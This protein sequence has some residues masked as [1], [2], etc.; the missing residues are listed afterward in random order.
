ML[1]KKQLKKIEELIRRKF[2]VFTYESLGERALT[3]DELNMLKDAGLLRSTVRSFTGDAFALGKVV[4]AIDRTKAIK[5]GFD[6][7]AKLAAKSPITTVEKYTIDWASEHTGQYIKGISDDMVK[8]VKTTVTRA[9]SSAIRAVQDEVVSAI[10]NRKT[11]SELKTA[12][13]HRIDDKYR[14]WQRVAQTEMNNAIQNGIYSSIRDK[15]GPDQLVYKRPNASACKHC[16]RVYLEDDGFTPIIFKMTD[17]KDSNYGLKA[18]NWE[19]TIGSVHPY[20]QC[21]LSVVPDG[22]GFGKRRVVTVPFTMGDKK[23][24]MGMQVPDGEFDELSDEHKGNVGY[25]AI[26]EYNGK[27]TRPTVK[28]SLNNLIISDM[29]DYNCICCY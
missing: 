2:L 27:T 12:L 11:V 28:K 21:Q 24:K 1:T 25:D 3:R 15:H 8:E 5:L 23:F 19:P 29:A 4:A 16:K 18:A 26:L 17:L 10:R 20:C 7:L 22:Y 14:D 9:A 6:D 13:F